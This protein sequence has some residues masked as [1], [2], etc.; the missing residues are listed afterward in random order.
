MHR[1]QPHFG[2]QYT[3]KMRLVSKEVGYV[4]EMILKGEHRINQQLSAVEV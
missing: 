1:V 2:N 3:Q 4:N